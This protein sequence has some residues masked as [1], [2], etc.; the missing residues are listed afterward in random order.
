MSS[1]NHLIECQIAER[2]ASIPASWSGAGSSTDGDHSRRV[3]ILLKRT[4]DLV[5]S[6]LALLLFLPVFLVCAVLIKSS[7]P[8]PVFYRAVRIGRD[9][10]QFLCWKFR[11]MYLGADNRK[12]ELQHLNQRDGVFFK[13]ADDPRVTAVGRYLRRY[14]CDELPQLFNVF[15]GDM[16]LVGPRPSLPEEYAEY[17]P[18]QRHR[19]EAMPGMTGLW[20]VTARRDPSFDTC[21]KYDLE[22]IR[23]WSVGLD[24][25]ILLKT[26]P[27][28]VM[29]R[30]E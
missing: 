12:S 25:K 17:T 10:R 8:G 21:I 18:Y 4:M 11:T 7:S 22:Y 24:V 1:A 23:D 16:S 28:V 5:G 14:S 20:Q 6:V 2:S 15:A 3:H 13:I 30:G 29:G 19:H 26:I 9:A 27:V